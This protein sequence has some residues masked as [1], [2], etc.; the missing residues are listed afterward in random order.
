MSAED[1]HEGK[2]EEKKDEEEDK[3]KMTEDWEIK[4]K[5]MIQCNKNW[6]FGWRWG[7]WEA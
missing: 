4:R 7:G 5:L 1:G 3:N 2:V 6:W